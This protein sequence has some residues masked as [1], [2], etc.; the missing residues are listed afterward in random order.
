MGAKVGGTITS[1]APTSTDEAPAD[2]NVVAPKLLAASVSEL[3]KAP[4][5]TALLSDS[6]R[7]A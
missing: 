3:V 6:D 4:L 5:D 7:A 2:D 1:T